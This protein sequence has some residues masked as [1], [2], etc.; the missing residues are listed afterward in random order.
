M[1]DNLKIDQITS[2]LLIF[3]CIG[4][5]FFLYS[6]SGDNGHSLSGAVGPP[7]GPPQNIRT[8]SLPGGARIF[9]TPPK[10]RN[11]LYVKAVFL[12]KTGG[13]QVVKSSSYNNSLTIKGF[14]NTT[15]HKVK[16]YSVGRG[17]KISDAA[18]VNVQPLLPTFKELYRSIEMSS[19]IG[20]IKVS[21][22][23]ANQKDVFRIKIIQDS[24]G[25]KKLFHTVFVKKPKGSVT[26]RGLETKKY[27]FG[28]YVVDEYQNLSDT[29]FSILHPFIEIE[30]P[31]DQISY[32]S[33]PFDSTLS[34][35]FS[36]LF[37]DEANRGVHGSDPTTY[38]GGRKESQLPTWLTMDLGK[39]YIISRVKIYGEPVIAQYT[40]GYPKKFEVWGSVDPELHPKVPFNS[41]WHKLGT[42]VTSPPK[43]EDKSVYVSTPYPENGVSYTI[44]N[45]F[46]NKAVRYLRIKVLE[47]YSGIPVFSLGELRIYA[48]SNE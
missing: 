2:G 15:T 39:K 3:I 26:I 36:N 23:N 40:G 4:I 16:L 1:E 44:Q 21:Y 6:C 14:A 32:V 22:S 20:G 7:P 38:F 17:G 24:S 37:D 43:N 29:T 27:K 5:A 34:I 31:T 12:T 42:F 9:Y 33:L 47:T 35:G 10:S 45:P 41:S 19:T 13:K 28:Y 8:E 25:V 46:S 18:S 11:L 48:T 30:V